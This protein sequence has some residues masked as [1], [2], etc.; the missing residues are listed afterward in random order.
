MISKKTVV[1]ASGNA[2]KVREFSK[3]FSDLGFHVKSMFDYA[4]L[5]EVIEDG[6]TFFENALKKAKTVAH[7]LQQ[8]VLAD[9]SGLAVDRL[10]G[11]PGVYSARYA[12]EDADDE[13]NNQKLI[14]ELTKLYP[15][16]D[17]D[18]DTVSNEPVLLSTARFI[19]T[20]VLYDPKTDIMIDA[21]GKWE[22]AI[23]AEP[24]GDG[25]FGYD[26]HFY[27][28]ALGKT[29]AQLDPDTKNKISHRGKALQQLLQ[30][31]S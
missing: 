3:Y 11:A 17:S 7:A 18:W 25:G 19:C 27:I 5:P 13:R 4:H 6:E 9:D 15:K 14:K 26:P 30:K 2:G 20:L 1:V 23:I 29:A 16:L 10:D 12:G 8:P 31:L 21:V 22:G 24:R 28:P